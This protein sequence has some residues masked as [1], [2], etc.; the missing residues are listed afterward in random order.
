M[1]VA[2]EV[3]VKRFSKNNKQGSEVSEEDKRTRRTLED[4]MTIFRVTLNLYI[5]ILSK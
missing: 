2:E 3:Y 4:E 5:D 1:V